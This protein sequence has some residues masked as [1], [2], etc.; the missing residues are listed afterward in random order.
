VVTACDDGRAR[1][2]QRAGGAAALELAGHTAPVVGAWPF[3][4]DRRVLTIGADGDAYLFDAKSGAVQR[5][6]QPHQRACPCAAIDPGLRLI[7]TGSSDR[8]VHVYDWDGELLRVLD[9]FPEPRA[10]TFNVE[11]NA[12]A[13]AFDAQRQRL[14]VA[15]R[16]V[17]VVFL[18]FDVRTWQPAV[19]A[20][21]KGKEGQEFSMHAAFRP[22]GRFYATAHSGVGDWTFV[23]A[24]Q[25]APLDIG[26]ANMP[27]TIVSVMRFSPTDDGLLLVGTRDGRASLWDLVAGERHAELRI[28]PDGIRCAEFSADGEWV[29]TGSQDGTLHVWPVHPLAFAREHHARLTGRR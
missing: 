5:R 12:S 7:A 1:V 19:V 11:G 29:A 17:K 27:D 9:T 26:E 6:L 8:T 18:I 10:P 2:W 16:C 15:N 13:L 23:D 4:A 14:V 24:D 22:G 20:Q 3:D 21:A 28:G 25:L